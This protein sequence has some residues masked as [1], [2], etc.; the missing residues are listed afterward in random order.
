MEIKTEDYSFRY[1]EETKTFIFDGLLRL[2]NIE[3]YAPIVKLMDEIVAQGFPLL[4]LDLRNLQ[5]LNSSGINMLSKFVLKARQQKTTQVIVR[6]SKDIPWQGKSL[7]SFQRLM[8][9]L[10][11]EF[12]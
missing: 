9:S 7:R 2:S 8:P 5:F 1:N 3:A 12:E 10:K 6:G 4:T 11:L